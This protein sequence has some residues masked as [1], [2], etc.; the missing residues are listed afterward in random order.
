MTNLRD[1]TYSKW[2]RTL[3]RGCYAMNL[4]WIEY[5]RSPFEGLK[6]VALIED[7]IDCDEMS[8]TDPNFP[9]KNNLPHWRATQKPIMTEMSRKL[10]VP[11]YLVLHTAC[12]S[13]SCI[14]NWI[15]KVEDLKTGEV[16]IMN[17]EGYRNF[18][19]SLGRDRR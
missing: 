13:N 9:L 1:L 4:D 8:L 11:A 6:I 3:G 5:R 19:E 10:G 14:K 16:S 18:I 17:E 2:H 7:K 12:E 15:F